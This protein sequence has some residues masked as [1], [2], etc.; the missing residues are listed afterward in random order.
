MQSPRNA[1]HNAPMGLFY[2]VLG[3]ILFIFVAGE[4][5]LRLIVAI[6]ALAMIFY[7]LKIWH[8][9]NLNFSQW[10]RFRDQD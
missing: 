6:C 9:K 7:G 10:R 2:L 8:G 1:P 3:S 5:I 4:F